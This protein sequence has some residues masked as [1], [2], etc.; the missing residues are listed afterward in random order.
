M[1][2]GAPPRCCGRMPLRW[3]L[4]LLAEPDALSLGGDERDGQTRLVVATD[5]A[6]FNQHLVERI[7]KAEAALKNLLEE[8]QRAKLEAAAVKGRAYAEAAEHAEQKSALEAQL[9]TAKADARN[10]LQGKAKVAA[11]TSVDDRA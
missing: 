11:D 2:A 4:A 10:A 7:E 9:A 5:P 8:K 6:E 1:L 3:L